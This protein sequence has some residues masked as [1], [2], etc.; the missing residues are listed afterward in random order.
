MKSP[1]RLLLCGT[2]AYKPMCREYSYKV[3]LS[4]PPPKK[5]KMSLCA[6]LAGSW[7]SILTF[8][9]NDDIDWPCRLTLVAPLTK[10]AIRRDQ[11]FK[12]VGR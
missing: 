2:H 6:I 3:K 1:G 8:F 4:P 12:K 7:D 10:M 9:T 11:W 5:K